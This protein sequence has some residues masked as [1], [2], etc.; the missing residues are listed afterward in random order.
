MHII[1]SVDKT[2]WKVAA[3]VTS[4]QGLYVDGAYLDR[5]EGYNFGYRPLG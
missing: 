5:L 3:V 4:Q 2:M 1:M